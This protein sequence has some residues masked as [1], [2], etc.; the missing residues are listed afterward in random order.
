MIMASM[1]QTL[2]RG[3]ATVRDQRLSSEWKS[4]TAA[5]KPV[6]STVQTLGMRFQ[7]GEVEQVCF[8]PRAGSLLSVAAW[9]AMPGLVR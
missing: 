1:G 7:G 2:R 4:F 8:C 9:P 3:N 5:G 6:Q